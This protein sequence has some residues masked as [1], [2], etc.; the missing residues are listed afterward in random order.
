MRTIKKLIASIITIVFMLQCMAIAVDIPIELQNQIS[1]NQYTYDH[2]MQSEIAKE[3]TGIRF[4]ANELNIELGKSVSL[5]VEAVYSDNSTA[6][7][8]EGVEFKSSNEGIATV[9]NTGTIKALAAGKAEITATYYDKHTQV[10]VTV[11]PSNQTQNVTPKIDVKEQAPVIIPEITVDDQDVILFVGETKK[12]GVYA[13]TNVP[14]TTSS[15][16]SFIEGDGTQE[17]NTQG[18]VTQGNNTQ[19]IDSVP[20]AFDNTIL[21]LTN[22]K[23]QDVSSN[24][25]TT[26][27]GIEFTASNEVYLTEGVEFVSS[28]TQIATVDTSGMIKAVSPGEALI[29]VKY[30][31]LSTVVNVTVL[32]PLESPILSIVEDNVAVRLSWT[33]VPDATSYNVKR[34][35]SPGKLQI[36]AANI[37]ETTYIDS[38]T[39]DEVTYFY[40]VTAAT[41]RAES[42]N[43]NICT[44]AAVPE[45][46]IVYGL[47]KSDSIKITWTLTYDA[48]K[49]NL[50]RRTSQGGS[51]EVIAE[52]TD[53]YQ[54]IDTNVDPDT[55][56]YYMV[57]AYDENGRS[58]KNSD[59]IE[60]KPLVIEEKKF[61]PTSDE[62]GDKVSNELELI[63]GTDV[64]GND[65]SLIE[66]AQESK[67]QE[68]VS[69]ELLSQEQILQG[70]TG[71]NK[72]VKSF[73]I[74]TNIIEDEIQKANVKIPKKVR[75]Q[76][77]S[78]DNKVNVEVYGDNDLKKAILSA[79][80]SKHK[81]LKDLEGAVG[82][83]V[84]LSAG[85]TE[86]NTAVIT[87][88]YDRNEL[89]G[90]KEDELKIYWFDEEKN[91]LVPLESIVDKANQTVSAQTP[92]FSTYILGD[93]S[94]EI[95]LNDVD[96][97]FVIDQSQEMAVSDPY[98]SR[99]ALAEKVAANVAE[100]KSP[101]IGVVGFSDYAIIKLEKTSAG[102]DVSEILKTF[103]NE[104][105][106]AVIIGGANIAD[107]IWIGKSLLEKGTELDGG[108]KKRRRVMILMTDGRDNQGNTDSHLE[109]IVQD[110]K[111]KDIGIAINTVSIG[112]ECN[113]ELLQNI[114][115]ITDG[116]YFALNIDA[117]LGQQD[118]SKQVDLI[119]NKL[120]KQM[121]IN[122]I[123]EPPEGAVLPTTDVSLGSVFPETYK[124]FDTELAKRLYTQTH[125][126]ILTGNFA[127]QETDININSTGPDLTIERTYNSDDGSSNT[128]LGNGWRLNYD[129]SVTEITTGGR[130]V[131]SGLNL[132]KLP[133]IDQQVISV[134]QWGATVNIIG[135]ET[136]GEILWLKVRLT[137]GVEGFV[138]SRY[139]DVS[140]GKGV[141][142]T[143]G[144]GTAAV[145][146]YN[147]E[148][149]KYYPTYGVSDSLT[150]TE[151]EYRL[152]RKDQSVYVY[153]ATTKKLKIIYDRYGNPVNIN[154]VDGRIDTVTDPVNRQLKFEYYENGL[155]KK[156][157]D[158]LERV[159]NYN[160]DV[161][162]N[163]TGV[164]DLN[165][166]T[167]TY[168]YY[169]KYV[170]EVQQ[171]LSI[172][173]EFAGSR[174]KQI[175]DANSHQVIKN[176]YDVYGRLVRQYDGNGNIKY[177]I[178]KDIYKDKNFEILGVNEMAR[179][180]IDENGNESKITFNP[181]TKLPITET[182]TYGKTVNH[183]NYV[184]R[185]YDGNYGDGEF[186]NITGI[187]AP[188]DPAE[189]GS[190]EYQEYILCVD[191]GNRHSQEEVTDTKG[192]KTT[193]IYDKYRNPIEII[194]HYQNKVTME[195]DSYNNLT[196]K[197]DKKQLP[198]QYNYS[199]DGAYLESTKDAIGNTTIYEYYQRGEATAVPGVNILINGLLKKVTV[200][201]M[202][203]GGQ[204]IKAFSTT[205]YK[206]EN[207]YNNRTEIIDDLKNSTKEVYDIAGRLKQVTNARSFTTKY[208][209]DNMDRLIS[210]EDALNY[211]STIQY[212]NVGNKH[213]VTDKNRNS[214]EY[215]YDNENQLIKVIDAKGYAV[216][217]KYDP[218]GNKIAEINQKGGITGYDYDAVGRLV[219]TT[220]PLGAA[221]KYE[222]DVDSQGTAD[223]AGYNNVKVTDPLGRVTITEYDELYRKVKER[224]QYDDNGIVKE[225]VTQYTY[226]LNDNLD[227]TIDAL[228]KVTKYSY[229]NLNRNVGIIDG[230]GLTE[231]ENATT[232]EYDVY[233]KEESKY[234]KVT[235]T[236]ALIHSTVNI[237]N[238][239]GQLVETIDA[240]QKPT[241]YT[242]DSVGNKKTVTDA[243]QHTVSYE[244]DELNR[245]SKAFDATEVNYTEMKYDAVGNNTE[246]IDRRKNRTQFRYNILNQL[247]ETEDPLNKVTSYGYDEA[248]NKTSV[249]DACGNVTRYEYNRNNQL[250]AEMDAAGFVKYYMY[251]TVGNK[252]YESSRKNEYVGMKFEYD[253][254]NRL[255]K[256]I[257]PEGTP[258]K[259]TY[260]VMGN[261]LSQT[262]GENRSITYEYDDDMHR[263]YK[264]IDGAGLEEVY[265]EYDLVGNLKTKVDRKGVTIKY[266]Y[267]EN[268]KLLKEAALGDIRQFTYDDVGNI[269]TATS[270]AGTTTYFYTVN[271]ELDYKEL[272]GNKKIDYDYDAEGNRT[273]LKD[274]EGN[275]TSY[276][277]DAANRLWKVTT[278]EGTN[279]YEYYDN[280]NRL[281]LTLANGAK[282]TYEYN[283][284]NLMTKLVNTVNGVSTTYEYDYDPDG[285][286]LYKIEPKG[287]TS[288]EYD[289]L[290]RIKTVVE[291]EGRTTTYT[292]D[293]SS[294]RKTQTVTG[295]G[296]N[297]SITYNY[298]EQNRLTDTIEIR[299]GVS[300]VTSYQYDDNGNQTR[301]TEGSSVSSYGYDNFNQLKAAILANGSAVNSKY[302]AFGQRIEKMTNG[303]T[304]TYYYDGQN[305]ILEIGSSGNKARNVYGINLIARDDSSGA[306]Y[307]QF[308]G[309]GD[310]VYL[311]D[312]NGSLINE[313]DYDIFGNVLKS[314]E[315]KPNPFRYAGYY[316]DSESNYY[317]LNARYYDP[318]TA[319]FI[320][321]D[322]YS[323]E[324]SDPL[325]LNLYTYCANNPVNYYDPSGHVTQ[326]DIDKYN[327][328]EIS[329]KQYDTVISLGEQWQR[330]EDDPSLPDDVKKELQSSLHQ[331]ANQ[332]RKGGYEW[333]DEIPDRVPDFYCL[334]VE[335]GALVSGGASFYIDKY[336]RQYGGLAG[337]VGVGTGIT[338][339]ITAGWIQ[340]DIEIDRRTVEEYLLG[341]SFSFTLGMVVGATKTWVP[342]KG[343]IINI[344]LVSP[345]IGVSASYTGKDAP[346]DYIEM[347]RRRGVEGY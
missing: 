61:D 51:Y 191:N 223:T 89:N 257:D 265:L 125:A 151:S 269:K 64:K 234:S 190:D 58:S 231:K 83:P 79:K 179:Y 248:G 32:I 189:L 240:R 215:I 329:K 10:T 6:P 244:Y 52:G 235:T 209:Y 302:D 175:V 237:T 304:T 196:L 157:T 93:K 48:V 77:K 112:N 8:S 217:Y 260:D 18:N 242:Y 55:T 283:S 270:E 35:T 218:V 54:Y 238:S 132:R 40:A 310:V 44:R 76:F 213:I 92:H 109:T 210:E 337:S 95:D 200:N 182:D 284:R 118:I 333:G 221:T 219:M 134:L 327:N 30:G 67:S 202:D 222:Y 251:D 249:K 120:I 147:S 135:S 105:G 28:N 216:Q 263:L 294:N 323:G 211:N 66:I 170:D 131:A 330:I 108:S 198:A 85:S 336:G 71:S 137:N 328:G 7:L 62:D 39:H 144:S 342:G 318:K 11:N 124:G 107:G 185:Y 183:Q 123:T 285:Q 50:Y 139:I 243:N 307:Y 2:V 101:R 150:R 335:G 266:D 41:D 255:V 345:Q 156:V 20:E 117:S 205:E 65:K 340:E 206:Y 75:R 177:H 254:L 293:K 47:R 262:D 299:N 214:T 280:G 246:K 37:T 274:P 113:S 45:A 258:T 154:Y 320:S 303:V 326:E 343:W 261:I 22:N 282:T 97:V 171:D 295:S 53:T 9:D 225:K 145:F 46:P 130:V 99:L 102:G 272:P 49:Y 114:A 142:V 184:Y 186:K 12:I 232:I 86:I 236:D 166:K 250:V 245:V 141:L 220:N 264:K 138:S 81:F 331:L 90:L 188:L 116:G 315:G 152:T 163:L 289:D 69:N 111:N 256:V 321:E 159:V 167:T 173:H 25:A 143:Y 133:G 305:V 233:Q 341:W 34:G 15:A 70:G 212:D 230:Y 88:K 227:T 84:E 57:K 180:F 82:N 193:T 140:K 153:D 17:D 24:P 80:E 160:Y 298:N 115:E 129:S 241:T 164:T 165:G 110:I 324:Y 63:N 279:T 74:Q 29:T 197:K 313:Y 226:D 36:I 19:V 309:H 127:Q 347:R 199:Q 42:K 5:N 73:G 290:G 311:V 308:N 187:Q 301:V 168:N 267:D 172:T 346:V 78:K 253:D 178:Y 317:Y 68:L 148:K 126:N 271:N 155:L 277:Y 224:A 161:N 21:D 314:I 104:D 162:G 194:D 4:T 103:N 96:I 121:M 27:A 31:E 16:A 149:N 158:P 338:A 119:Y 344:G 122:K 275:E 72:Q 278:S 334:T 26:P 174:I 192:Y 56:Y 203:K 146:L 306:L 316:Y 287:T 239:L 87:M 297:C 268:G 259:Y 204:E 60:V 312:V 322:T 201:L 288:F 59:E 106:K 14:G 128:M 247:Y 13:K 296:V 273:Y 100:I 98:G 91:S 325:S 195:Y 339:S 33:N 229:D 300:T 169:D 94:L 176:D 291:P 3:L 136:V 23:S 228:G 252:T 1:I 207:G 43:S 332:Y 319:R 281:S 38:H 292:Y 181:V 286:Q 208:E 276:E